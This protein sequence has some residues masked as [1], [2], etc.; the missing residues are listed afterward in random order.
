M[1]IPSAL[2]YLF[3]FIILIITLVIGYKVVKKFFIGVTNEPNPTG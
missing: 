1:Y 2:K 3:I